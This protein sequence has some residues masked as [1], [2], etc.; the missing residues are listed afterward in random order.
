MGYIPT[1]GFSSQNWPPPPP[2]DAMCSRHP[3]DVVSHAQLQRTRDCN[4][5]DHLAYLRSRRQPVATSRAPYMSHVVFP[6]TGPT[7]T[8]QAGRVW[9]VPKSNVVGG[10]HPAWPAV[11]PAVHAGPTVTGLVTSKNV[12]FRGQRPIY[13]SRSDETL[14]TVSSH[15]SRQ[16]HHGRR[17]IGT[18]KTS[19]RAA[20]RSR[21]HRERAATNEPTAS[22]A[23]PVSAPPPPASDPV[24]TDEA[25]CSA[26][27]DEHG[28]E[29]VD[30]ARVKSAHVDS[31]SNPDSGYS[32]AS[33]TAVRRLAPCSESSS[34]HSASSGEMTASVAIAASEHSDSVPSLCNSL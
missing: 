5:H 26:A 8:D 21:N 3:P 27:V 17:C 24:L 14:S 10:P 12:S 20:E 2:N 19:R 1:P 6:G 11:P 18:E 30:P 29:V 32:G 33:G 25:T 34:L 23:V 22:Q 13:R 15:A 4:H 16:R 31:S 28:A 9:P 7:Y